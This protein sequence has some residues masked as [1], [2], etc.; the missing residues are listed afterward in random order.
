MFRTVLK[1]FDETEV[2]CSV[3]GCGSAAE[4]QSIL[5]GGGVATG[6]EKEGEGGGGVGEE[7]AKALD[8]I[9]KTVIFSLALSVWTLQGST[10]KELSPLVSAHMCM[11]MTH[12]HTCT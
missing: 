4:I 2:S 6:E 1:V 8:R 5:F 7:S 12:V 9:S 3:G 11:H 10:L